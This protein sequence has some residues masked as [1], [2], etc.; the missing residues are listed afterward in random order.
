MATYTSDCDKEESLIAKNAIQNTACIA[1]CEPT[2]RCMPQVTKLA[3]GIIYKV[4]AKQADVL[5]VVGIIRPRKKIKSMTKNA[6]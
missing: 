3:I 6:Q 2:A 4:L 1:T 5:K